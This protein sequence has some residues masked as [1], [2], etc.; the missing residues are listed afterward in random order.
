MKAGL[1]LYRHMLTRENFRFARQAGATHIVAHWVD[2]FNSPKNLSTA[3]AGDAWGISDNRDRLW[4]WEEL[5]D[6]RA[7]VKAEGLELEAIE[8]FDPS[9]WYD[10]LLDGPRR[11]QQIEGIKSNIRALGRAGIP[12][13][14]YYFSVAGAWGR[15]ATT[16]ARGGAPAVGYL[17]THAPE[18]TPIP[19]GTAWNMVYDPDAPAGFVGPVSEDEVWERLAGFL[20]ELV[21]VAEEAGVRLAAHP[22]DPPLPVLRNTGRLLYHPDRFERL[23]SI[24]PSRANA[25]ELCLGTV[26]EMQGGDIYEVV[27]RHSRGGQI[28]YI[29]FRN[30][31][32]KVPNYQEVFID[33]GDVDMIRVL[34]ILKRNHYD[35]VLIPDH[36]PQMTCDAPWHAG[37][38]YALGY[39]NA[40]IRIIEEES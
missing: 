21:P 22:D 40:A 5:R 31:R 8:N 10:I 34:R 1:G 26:A 32:G 29:H 35:G 19:L 37:M 13:M 27:D 14:G 9:H 18:Q 16:G 39:M 12:V 17:Q 3:S 23:L 36:T 4:N 28:G 11:A 7:A 6:L 15:H 30:V 38:A 20:T 2:Y 25:L 24:V 33:E